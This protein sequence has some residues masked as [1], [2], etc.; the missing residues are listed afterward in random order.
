[1]KFC[2]SFVLAFLVSTALLAQDSAQGELAK[3]LEQHVAFLASDSL[4]GRGLGTDGKIIAKNYIANQFQSIGLEKFNDEG[5]FQK[6][7]LRVSL[8]RVDAVNVI[9]YLKGS[10]PA[11]QNEFVV[12]GAHFDH[13]GYIDKE[14]EKGIYH[15]ADDNASGV[16]AMIELARFFSGNRDYAKRSIIF[17]AFDAE[18]SGLLGSTIFLNENGRFE[19]ASIRVM[20]SLDMVGMYKANNG[21]DL[22]G[23]GTLNEGEKIAKS[24]A[25][26]RNFLLKKTTH[27]VEMRTDTW[28][29]GEKGIPAIHA[30]TGSKSPYHKPEDT[31]DKLD[32]EGMASV[33][34]YLQELITE[35]SAM[36]EI[37]P[38]RSFGRLQNPKTVRFDAGVTAGAGISHHK[39]PD[40]FF[41]PRSIFAYNAGLFMQVNFGK[42]ITLQPEVLFQSDGS[43]SKDGTFRRQSVIIP[44][45]LHVNLVHEYGGLIRFYPFA[46][47]YYL[48]SFEGKNGSN[49]IDFDEDFSDQE[50]G[51]NLGIG[52]DI[53]DWQV[54]LTWRRSLTNLSLT[55]D[56]KIY[57]SA[58]F[59][60][61][62]YKF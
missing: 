15:G 30:F 53:M 22:D 38:T 21:L 16:A 62:G 6:F 46:G 19:T 1:M 8:V 36:P 23:I 48:Y 29:F 34:D 32:Y 27:D 61:V 3:R 51:M 7:N 18:E 11:L 45:N 35:I 59:I 47:G 42:W 54:N 4:E 39:Y 52:M 58:W 55:S 10:D 49:E 5:Y 33:T 13:L 60:S 37:L 43:K 28:P 12:I 17:I 14:D 24:I 9:G 50:W 31:F 20:F 41:N 2:L 40:E 26:A 44:V 56:T 25:S 57:P